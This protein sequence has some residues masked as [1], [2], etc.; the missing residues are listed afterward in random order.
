MH[1]SIQKIKNFDL[2]ISISSHL[3]LLSN[4]LRFTFCFSGGES[5]FCLRNPTCDSFS[6][7]T[8]FP[9]KSLL[10]SSSL[11]FISQGRVMFKKRRAQTKKQS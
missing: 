8:L 9:L 11:F 2:L 4:E 6:W 10:S 3:R 5:N 1:L 7:I